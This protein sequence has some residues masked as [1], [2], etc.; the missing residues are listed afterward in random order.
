MLDQPLAEQLSPLVIEPDGSV[1]P[2]QYGFA[3]SFALGNLHQATLPEMA[4]RWRVDVGPRLQ[5]VS[6]ELFRVL[7]DQP[8]QFI[9]WYALM[10]A[11]ARS[12]TLPDVQRVLAARGRPSHLSA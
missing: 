10:A 9:D 3:R 7:D 4:M 2:L 12:H 1:V 11:Q 5:A 8:S 6:R